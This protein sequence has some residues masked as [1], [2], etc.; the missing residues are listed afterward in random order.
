MNMNT[1][2]EEYQYLDIV[3]EIIETGSVRN[4]RTGTGTISKF[5]RTMTFSLRDGSFPLLTTKKVFWRGI[6]EEMLWFISGNTS[7]KTLSEK[8]VKIW[9]SQGS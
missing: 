3:K 4:D 7:S 2:S 6:A 8:G 5:G 1:D 9:D